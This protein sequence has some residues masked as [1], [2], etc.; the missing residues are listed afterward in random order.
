MSRTLNA[1]LATAQDSQTHHPICSLT[2]G[3]GVADIPFQENP[4]VSPDTVK[5]YNPSPAVLSDG[6][7]AAFYTGAGVSGGNSQIRLILSDADR[8]A[9]APYVT[10]KYHAGV[11]Y[12]YIDSIVLD[13]SDNIGV[14][15]YY[16]GTIETLVVTSAGALSTTGTV[17][18]A[19]VSGV[20]AVV[21]GA[22]SYAMVYTR[23]DGATYKVCL[24]TSADFQ[25]WSAESVL[26]IGDIV[27]TQAVQHPRLIKQADDTYV[28]IF[29][30]QDYVDDTGS[31]YNIW[32]S[33]STDLSTWAD[34]LPIT[35][36][37]LKSRDYSAP[38]VVQRDDGSLF[39]SAVESNTYLSMTHETTG[40]VQSESGNYEMSPGN[41][42]VD[43]A[44]G[45]VYVIS[46]TGER[47]RGVAKIDLATW[48]IDACYTGYNSPVFPTVFQG[49]Y[50]TA[51]INDRTCDG[52]G[53]QSAINYAGAGVLLFDFA[54]ETFK[55]FMFFDRSA[56]FGEDAAKNVNWTPASVS[57]INGK[58]W[59]D[60]TNN[61]LY[62]ALNSDYLHD[63]GYQFGYIDLD[64]SGP[65]YDFTELFSIELPYG[66]YAGPSV[67]HAYLD[68]GLVMYTG[69]GFWGA[70]IF[71]VHIATGGIYKN[72]NLADYPE[73]PLL[74]CYDACVIG[75][76][77]YGL[78]KYS[79]SPESEIYK[80]GIIEIDLETDVMTY[81][82][83][84]FTATKLWTAQAWIDVCTDTTEL[85]ITGQTEPII[86][87]YTDKSWTYTDYNAEGGAPL[88][89]ASAWDHLWYDY[90]ADAFFGMK[91]S[92]NVLYMLPRDGVLNRAVYSVGTTFTFS[93]VA[94]L[95]D[96]YAAEKP[97]MALDE[98]NSIWTFWN[99]T[100][101]TDSS[102]SWGKTEAALSMLQY[103]TGE[104]IA[105]WN[106]DGTPSTLQFTLSHGHLFDP[107]NSASILNFYLEKGNVATLQFGEVVS[108]T[109]YL[110]N[111][112]EYVVREIK[113]R[114]KRG[115]YPV[116]QVT[117]EDVR[118]LWSMHQIAATQSSGVLPGAAIQA[119]IIANTPLEDA[120]F[121][122]PVMTGGF[123]FDAQW[124]DTYLSDI[125]SDIAHRFGYFLIP[126]MDGL[127]TARL[128]DTSA[129]VSHTYSTRDQIIEFTPDDSFSDLVNRVTVTGQSED[130][131]EVMYAEERLG[132]LNGTIG[133]WGFQKD[134]YVYYS[135][136]RSKRAK[137]P[138]LR[139]LESSTSIMFDLAGSVTE[140]IS[141][142]DPYHKYC[143]VTIEA[144]NL[145]PILI[146]AIAGWVSAHYIPDKVVSTIAGL[147]IPWGRVIESAFLLVAL[148]VLGSVAN[149]QFEVWGCPLGYVKRDYS[150]SADDEVLQSKI[151]MV[152]E[153]KQEGFLA[154]TQ[155]Q[156]QDVAD[157]EM[158]LTMLQRNRV[159]F[160]KTAHLQ[161]EVGD[162]ISIPHPYTNT[163]MRVMIAGL[164]RRYLPE[165]D[166]H[167]IDEIDGWRL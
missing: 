69:P 163:A 32:Y 150:A 143:V 49:G 25:T 144:P 59:L 2:I 164:K 39:V 10:I 27:T 30:Y 24:R 83:P 48:T 76:K 98:D 115:E 40:W 15:A 116:A 22:G 54:T 1:T 80:Y 51:G 85:I 166:G 149:Y 128:I 21:V 53:D 35:D 94:S 67:V 124:L 46:N 120:D 158:E 55:Y 146:A 89:T 103:L 45:K 19:A 75:G 131:I 152:I 148:N 65:T 99:D 105:E 57:R 33:T 123:Q 16:N 52:S 66:T 119:I 130:D 71:L 64:Q 101:A 37:T 28:L 110:E 165:K 139:V 137:F 145:T 9:F 132:S 61:L 42:W 133:W 23:L 36:T 3:K 43:S 156:C 47:F 77:I 127:I 4:G 114:Y 8:T 129:A 93:A 108:G 70:H 5:Q 160:T 38:D 106:I 140:R 95:I 18:V 26:T 44:N 155:L 84:S 111:Q 78:T 92:T 141:Y 113:L 112:G 134:F 91:A 34:A 142:T 135:D 125:V 97:Q 136:D 104:L 107:Q 17:S 162:I 60:A 126:D 96:S 74:G 161:D 121:D 79:S 118:C 7:L 41:L 73:F 138:R 151:G 147:T 117:C 62:V 82:Y 20:S 13:A 31:I 29:S 86:F 153:E 87:N 157:F 50:T 14:I 6:R 102:I 159:S 88:P 63:E 122:M 100:D 154:N 58:C 68:A 12:L 167:F 109:D 11:S 81:H 90:T 56:E 72:Y